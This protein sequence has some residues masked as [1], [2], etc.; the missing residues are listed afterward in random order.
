MKPD[1]WAPGTESF[2]IPNLGVTLNLLGSSAAAAVITR[3]V[4]FVWQQHPS[5]EPFQVRSLFLGKV[6]LLTDQSILWAGPQSYME[7]RPDE[8]T[9]DLNEQGHRVR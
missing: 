4:A 2:F 7:T 8:I 6:L 1:V 3:V 9:K 5:L